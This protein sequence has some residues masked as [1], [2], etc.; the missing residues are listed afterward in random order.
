MNFGPIGTVGS[1]F[2]EQTK[3]RTQL[4]ERR[5]EEREQE[6]NPKTR[7]MI[8][9]IFYRWDCMPVLMKILCLAVENYERILINPIR[10]PGP[11]SSYSLVYPE[12]CWTRISLLYSAPG[13]I[14]FTIL[15]YYI[16]IQ[17]LESTPILILNQ[18]KTTQIK[19]NKPGSRVFIGYRI[20]QS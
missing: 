15:N 13:Y 7:K 17:L 8:K 18:E 9:C 11:W 16:Y 4:Y 20:Y 10:C 19:H 2:I 5:K 6:N 14:G 12:Q 3:Q 1:K